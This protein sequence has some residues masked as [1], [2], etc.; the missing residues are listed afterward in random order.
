MERPSQPA[1]LRVL[2]TRA[3][4]TANHALP[5]ERQKAL[6]VG[7]V[8]GGPEAVEIYREY[9]KDPDL[10]VRTLVFQFAVEAE[11]GGLPAIRAM[12]NDPDLQLNHRVFEHL[13][14]SCD[15]QTTTAV[16]GLINDP[17][18]LRRAWAAIIIGTTAGASMIMRVQP[19]AH[20]EHSE[21]QAAAKW[22]LAKMNKEECGPPPIPTFD[23][24]TTDAPAS[25]PALPVPVQTE[26]SQ[27]T[28][29]KK[30]PKYDFENIGAYFNALGQAQDPTELAKH[31]RC[32]T[33]SD[34]SAGLREMTGAHSDPSC[35]RGAIIAAARTGNTRWAGTIRKL[36]N[37]PHPG[38]RAAVAEALGAL[39]TNAVSVQ[40]A[41]MLNDEHGSVRAAAARGLAAGAPKINSVEWALGLLRSATAGE[42][43][44]L[45]KTFDDAIRQLEA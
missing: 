15:G 13:F 41:Q 6:R 43:E 5:E 33:D 14:A 35:K 2:V 17:Q 21:V 45:Q 12:V 7:R 22:A 40:L 24:C 28:T 37:D 1:I 4:S 29:S 25:E 42:D 30:P 39:C 18:P 44:G 32:Y 8:I 27:K 31:I 16:R 10:D 20:D 38:V 11:T 19:L 9:A 36:H 26:S 23:G 3:R 34:L